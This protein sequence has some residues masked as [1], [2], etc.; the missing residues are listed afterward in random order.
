MAGG[1]AT[2]LC[3]R[4]N[5]IPKPMIPAANAPM[6]GVRDGMETRMPDLRFPFRHFRDCS[7]CRPPER[8]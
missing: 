1:F 8:R 4:T 7:R 5:N 6:A 3:P 2:G